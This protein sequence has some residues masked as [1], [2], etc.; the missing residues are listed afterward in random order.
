MYQQLIN[1]LIAI[2][3][4][5]GVQRLE[6]AFDNGVMDLITSK[7][8]ESPRLRFYSMDLL[9]ALIESQAEMVVKQLIEHNF[10]QKLPPLT[11]P[12]DMNE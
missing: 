4:W 2:A 11:Q 6:Y 8:A 3:K 1:Y 12:F 5:G 9:L 7:M 10:F